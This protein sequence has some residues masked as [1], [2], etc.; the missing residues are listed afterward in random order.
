MF[1]TVRYLWL[2]AKGTY[3]FPSKRHW[4]DSAGS[5]G[6]DRGSLA[7]EIHPRV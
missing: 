5:P 2:G 4:G 6:H 7:S 1:S 3:L